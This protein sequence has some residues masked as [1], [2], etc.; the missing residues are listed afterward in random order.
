MSNDV[1]II[2]KAGIGHKIHVNRKL[3]LVST[4]LVFSDLS[5]FIPD[6]SLTLVKL[7]ASIMIH[8]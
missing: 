7:K 6:A 2:K 1:L 4:R 5:D 8:I 3:N